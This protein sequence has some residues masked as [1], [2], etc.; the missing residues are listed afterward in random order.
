MKTA[1]HVETSCF[2]SLQSH[3]QLQQILDHSIR[4]F[5]LKS[6]VF[7][8]NTT[9]HQLHSEYP[10]QKVVQSPGRTD[11]LDKTLQYLL[12]QVSN[13]DPNHSDPILE[14]PTHPIYEQ[15]WVL[16]FYNLQGQKNNRY[17]VPTLAFL[18]MECHE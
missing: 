9:E 16:G 13:C 5:T 10:P 7:Y 15:E 2:L 6:P 11:L 18:G 4:Q 3:S 8:A 1:S 14:G 17:V 12:Q